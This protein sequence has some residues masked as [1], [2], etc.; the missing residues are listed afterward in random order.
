MVLVLVYCWHLPSCSCPGTTMDGVVMCGQMETQRRAKHRWNCINTE[1]LVRTMSGPASVSLLYA[2]KKHRQLFL[3][4][5]VVLHV[6]F[7]SCGNSNQKAVLLS[8]VGQHRTVVYLELPSYRIHPFSIQETMCNTVLSAL[9]VTL[10][11]IIVLKRWLPCQIVPSCCQ[12]F[13]WIVLVV[14]K[15]CSRFNI[16]F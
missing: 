3:A 5:M 11:F 16:V 13:T 4:D 8:L 1:S 2:I 12:D 15:F 6:V 9:Q 10:N 7:P 14:S